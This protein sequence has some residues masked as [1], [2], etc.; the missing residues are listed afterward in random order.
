MT[1]P[2]AIGL[3]Q[4]PEG[5]GFTEAAALGLA[6]TA[7]V[8]SFDAAQVGDGAT[9]LIAGATGG[10]GQQALRLAVRAG[11]EVVATASSQEEI[12]LVTRLGAAHTVDYHGDVAQQVAALYPEGVDVVLHFAGA[13]L[14]LVPAV[15][16]GGTFVS[17]MLQSAA[18]VPAEGVEVVSIYASPTA[19]TLDRVARHQ[20]EEHT[21]VT[22]QRVYAL[23]Q[24]GVAFG[25]FAAGTLGKLVIAIN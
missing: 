6:G 12:E 16:Q 8:D 3:A 22:V 9:V 7:A 18:D 1:V 2:T 15:K 13:S 17:T 20:A 25:D 23:D 21:T 11:A 19:D 14:P 10:V 4:L 5:I 24:A